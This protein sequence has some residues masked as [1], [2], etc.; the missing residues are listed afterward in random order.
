MLVASALWIRTGFHA[1]PDRA[2]K[3]VRIQF[4]IRIKEFDEQGCITSLLEKIHFFIIYSHFCKNFY[5]LK[6]AASAA[7][8]IP[9]CRRRPGL[10]P[11]FVPTRSHPLLFIKLILHLTTNCSINLSPQLYLCFRNA[12]FSCV[13]SGL[14][15]L[16]AQPKPVSLLSRLLIPVPC[17]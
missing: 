10:I 7:S 5:V 4:C 1:N 13:L 11:E 8:Q 3:S 2:F 16:A 6:T 9:Q 12:F 14:C 15:P 17:L